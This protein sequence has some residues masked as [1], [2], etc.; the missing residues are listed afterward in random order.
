M[1]GIKHINIKPNKDSMTD[2]ELKTR[3]YPTNVMFCN[4]I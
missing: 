4:D 3:H 1:L 2:G